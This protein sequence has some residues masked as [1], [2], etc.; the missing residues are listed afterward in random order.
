MKRSVFLQVV[1]RTHARSKWR[2]VTI[3]GRRVSIKLT[4]LFNINAFKSKN[5][6]PIGAKHLP[7][8]DTNV[9]TN[10]R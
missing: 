8:K 2:K 1:E 3:P 10:R 6:Q 5:K 4:S 7:N 9:L